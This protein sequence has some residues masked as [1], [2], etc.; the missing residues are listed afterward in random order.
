MFSLHEKIYATVRQVPRGRVASYGQIAR[1]TGGCTAR[2]VGYAMAATPP[3]SGIPW[4]RVINSRGGISP[5]SSGDGA[6][7]QRRLLE[8]EGVEFD[9]R[10]RVD[11]TR[12]GWKEP[13][14]REEF[15]GCHGAGKRDGFEK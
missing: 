2:Q 9:L 7:R 13:M 11:F 10:G 1:L 15:R 8:A 6:A 3:G 12:F 4:H 14:I 5:R